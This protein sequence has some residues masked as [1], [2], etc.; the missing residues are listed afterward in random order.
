M[1]AGGK[2]KMIPKYQADPGIPLEGY[3][4]FVE[5]FFGGGAMTIH[6]AS[7]APKIKRFIINDIN[8]ELMELYRVIKSDP[9]RFMSLCD[10]YAN[11]YLTLDK[12][13]R[14]TYYYDIRQT[15]VDDYQQWDNVK[16][17]ATLYFLMKTAFNGIWQT[18]KAA[19]GRFCT[20]CGL[21]N[22]RD[23]VYDRDLILQWHQ[24]LQRADIMCGDWQSAAAASDGRTFYYFDPPYRDSFTQYAQVFD[25]DAHDELIEFSREI[26]DAGHIA[27]YAGRSTDDGFYSTR[28]GNLMLK[29][30]PITYTAGRRSTKVLKDDQGKE[31][32]VREAKE[33]TEILLCS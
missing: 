2:T 22:H 15:Y 8:A 28:Q 5:P 26:A 10:V 17:S 7:H 12:A 33:A 11:H 3:D 16:Q 4:T 29:T 24:F 6:L 9:H 30:Y 31:T 25:D 32:T 19:G 1:W 27:W 21:L 23:K 20:P 14:K 18:T 13:S